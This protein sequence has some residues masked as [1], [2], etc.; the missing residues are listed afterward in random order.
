MADMLAIVVIILGIV[1]LVLGVNAVF[2][3]GIYAIIRL[4]GHDFPFWNLFGITFIGMFLLNLLRMGFKK[5][6]DVRRYH[7]TGL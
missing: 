7:R 2:T 5:T 4:A 3:A 6:H 1:A